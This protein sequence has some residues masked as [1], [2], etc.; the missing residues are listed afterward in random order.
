MNQ[1]IAVFGAGAIGTAF[2]FHL[3]RAGHA[4][5]VV[6]RGARLAQLRKDGGIV[7]A[8]GARADVVVADAL[9]V[10]VEFDLLLVTV[11][12]PQV[13]AVLP[14]L[15]ASRARRV[16]FM[17]NTFD[18]I[19]PLREAVGAD[20]FAFGFPGGVFSLIKDGR[21]D[22]VV[23]RGTTVDDGVFA[24]LFSAAGIPTETTPDMHAWL[25][26]HAALVV[27]MMSV[28]VRAFE[29]GR[30]ATWSEA[31]DAAV[32][33]KAAFA[34]VRELGHPVLPSMAAAVGASPTL[35]LALSLWAGSRARLL[36]DLG[37]LGPHE[38]RMLIDQMVATRPT[39][40]AAAA[41]AKIRP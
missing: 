41:L 25:R 30:G 22:H 27:G 11:L 3:A 8:A 1:R 39:S 20:R 2:A 21:I 23:R 34:L 31:M 13:A 35:L 15:T 40:K 37:A 29:R 4:V 32:A 5:T 9:D 28:G 6:A 33:T 26:S 17:F 18:P 38:P 36:I 7:T 10:D 19:A 16:M 12:A 14:Q 24:S